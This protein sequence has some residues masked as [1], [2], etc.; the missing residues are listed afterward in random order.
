M[1][2]K[3]NLIANYVGQGWSALMGFA[4]LPMYIKILGIEAYALIGI[5]GLLQ[6]WFSLLDIG[7]TPTLA[8]EMA[9]FKG[10]G[11][12]PQYIRNLL[13]SI[14]ILEYIFALVIFLS[15]WTTSSWLASDWVQVENLSAKTVAQA[16]SIMGFVSALRFIETTYHSC[17]VGLQH[18]ILL[19]LITAIASTLRGLGSVAILMWL[20]P[21]IEAFFLWQGLISLITVGVYAS[22]LYRALPKAPQPAYFSLHALQKIWGFAGG[23]V[24]ITFLAL[25][26]TQVDKL[27]LSKLLT[28]KEFGYYTLAATI[29]GVLHMLLSPI[30]QAY[31]PRFTELFASESEIQLTRIYHQAAQVVTVMIGSIAIIFITFSN[32]ILAL[33]TRNTSIAERVAPLLA[34]LALGNFLNCLMH[35]P[36]QMQLAYGWTSL[37]FKTNL[38]AV[39]L[40]VPG[41]FLATSHYG[42]IGAAWVWVSLNAGYVVVGVH[43]MYQRLL[44]KEKWRWYLQDIAFPLVTG[45]ITGALLKIVSNYSVQSIHNPISILTITFCGVFFAMVLAAPAI[46]FQVLGLVSSRSKVVK[47]I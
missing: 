22:V 3:K 15:V 12:E 27:L 8:R 28:L 2:L 36:Y 26:L 29:A 38:M 30:T 39:T 40:I 1:A 45:V 42:A 43:F 6:S 17:L 46:R 47:G 5:L 37:A 41:I 18:Q 10:E 16:F 13:R 9:R 11:G 24:G 34:V 31:Y 14:E 23:M 32:P 44:T 25:L 4:F 20:S 33:W 7:M 35:I 21:T 19:N